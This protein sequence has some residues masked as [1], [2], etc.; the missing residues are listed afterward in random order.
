ML[1]HLC[2]ASPCLINQLVLQNGIDTQWTFDDV[3]RDQELRRGTNFKGVFVSR[4]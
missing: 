3:F 4:F 1:Y 2:N